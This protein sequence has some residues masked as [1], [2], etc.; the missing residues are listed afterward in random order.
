M[1]I[2]AERNPVVKY[3]YKTF[4][5]ITSVP[6]KH[7]SNIIITCASKGFSGKMT[8]FEEYSENHRT[9]IGHFLNKG[10]WDSDSVGKTLSNKVYEYTYTNEPIVFMSLDDTVNEKH[11]ASDRTEKPM[12]EV[13]SVY[14]HLKGGFVYGHQV[15]AA[16]AGNLCYKLDFCRENDGGKIEKAVSV[17]K[18]LPILDKPGY[19]LM[20]SWYTCKK[21][22]NA[23]SAK[24]Y[25]IIGALKSNR[26]IY[27][28]DDTGSIQIAQFAKT[29]N[30]SDFRLV[31]A[32]SG[33]YWVYRYTG[34]LNG[35]KESVVLITYPENAFGKDNAL[36]AFLCTDLSLSDETIIK[37]YGNRWKIEVFF[38]QHKHYFGFNKYQIRSAVG[39]CR[40]LLLISLASFYFISNF[41]KNL[42]DAIKIFRRNFKISFDFC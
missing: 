13:R 16:M 32:K 17:A 6:L 8:E 5:K 37:Y 24:N 19:V 29:L 35:V 1:A 11:K 41:G 42:A 3:L 39:I 10:K 30:L 40:F 23:F 34:K 18:S 14:S 2:I 33:K 27:P 21:V 15:F 4:E 31:T 28:N 25:Y 12:E 36:R 7:I 26:V 38:K 20:D 22:I 9:T